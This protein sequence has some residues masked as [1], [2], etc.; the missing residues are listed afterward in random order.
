MTTDEGAPGRV[1]QH[2]TASGDARIYLAA[3][4]QHIT[5]I[6]RAP[7][8]L[9]KALAALPAPPD[10]LVGRRTKVDEL[11]TALGPQGAPGS[12]TV[13]AVAG[14]AGVGKTALALHTAQQAATRGMFPGGVLFVALRG[15][16][17]TGPVTAQ[18]ALGILLRQLGV[19][20]ED[21]PGE[22]EELAALYRSELARRAEQAGAVLIVADD[23][24]GTSQLTDLVPAQRAHRLLVTSRDTLTSPTF[25]ARLLRLD[26]LDATAAAEL[27]CSAVT[28]ARPDDRRI[29]AEPQALADVVAHCGR[30]PLALQI[31]AALLTSDPGLPVA[32]LAEDLAGTLDAL[33]FHD[34][35]GQ[36]LAVRA[37]FDLSH[38]RLAPEPARVFR[39]LGLC[40]G[41]DL[42]T[43]SAAALTDRPTRETRG[44]L[45][46]IAAAGLLTEQPVGSGR[47]RMHDLIRL[48]TAELAR[49]ATE[50]SRQALDRLIRRYTSLA[51]A[52]DD[53]LSAL[54]APEFFDDRTQ[55]LDWLD[56]EH[57]TLVATIGRHPR[58][59][60]NLAFCLQQ[61]LL[62]RRHFDDALSTSRHALTA[63]Q[64]LGDRHS[65]GGALTNLGNALHEVRRFE[66][67]V[68][69]HIRAAGI[70]ADLRD[71]QSEGQAVNNLG[72][73]LRVMRRFDEAIDVLTRATGIFAERGDRHREGQAVNNLGNALREVGRFE[74]AVDALT[75]AT[76]IFAERGDRRRE[77]QAVN[78]LGN[79]LHDLG[80]FEEAIEAH[81]R[82]EGIFAEQGDRHSEG[83]ALNN[84]G[85]VLHDVGRF[86]E[87]IE[88][89]TRAVTIYRDLGDRHSEGGALNNLG[90][91]LRAVGR[92]EEAIDVLT[93][94]VT[95]YRDLGDQ[96]SEGLAQRNLADAT[97]EAGATGGWWR[98]VRGRRSRRTG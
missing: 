24:S 25:R 53:L 23:A 47:W 33:Q 64:E 11:L 81:T 73:A 95:V 43:E 2:V 39:L 40:A 91:A 7:S 48:Y 45:A 15:Y 79:A 20:D 75:R 13:A 90:N 68:E 14:L 42:A 29:A 41:P 5:N 70:F 92:F 32:A 86:E 93:R 36:S 63:T 84:L 50:E 12:A 35:D 9:P 69:A 34:T 62:L 55:A 38:R 80:R 88:A 30:L 6:A 72:S 97:A 59:A 65:E 21:L 87:A 89:H 78:N 16:D 49:P 98:R 66:E 1:Q 57:P 76:G 58:D 60:V 44:A 27:V 37:A 22:A 54:P 61:F 18:R 85:S 94:A 52:A 71:R 31:A 4:D 83:Q 19:R 56:A 74:E 67:A 46:A 51:D 8:P 3:H 82:A 17:P 96:H 28:L 10:H 26:E 77:G